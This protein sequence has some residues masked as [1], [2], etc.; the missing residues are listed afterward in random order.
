MTESDR[1]EFARLLADVCGFYREP[2]T[3]FALSVWWAACQPFPLNAVRT[4]MTSHATDPSRGQFCPK[5]A[6]VIRQLRGSAE[7]DALVAWQRVFSQIGSVGRYGTPKLTGAE[8][9]ALGAIGGW[10]ALCNSQEDQ[11]PFL[12]RQFAANYKAAVG[13]DERQAL[14]EPPA[15]IQQLAASVIKIARGGDE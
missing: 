14:L 8:R 10:S 2:I 4:A 5:P 9:A 11:V 15:E 7:D 1:P 12:A 3:E 6:D 13:N